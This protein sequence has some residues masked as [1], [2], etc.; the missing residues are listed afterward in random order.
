[1]VERRSQ[2]GLRVCTYKPCAE[3]TIRL[4][5]LTQGCL[6]PIA[7]PFFL[8]VVL[9]LSAGCGGVASKSQTV[10][11][12]PPAQDFSIT[13]S[14]TSLSLL[15]GGTSSPVNV[16]IAGQNGFTGTVQVSLSGLPSAVQSNPSSPF[17][18]AAGASTSVLFG[19]ASNAAAGNFTITAQGSSG[20]LSHSANLSLTVQT[21]V[22]SALPRTTYVRTGATAALDDPPSEPHHHHLVYHPSSKR[23]FIANRALNRVEVFS[24]TDQTRLA[25]I[26]VP[27][28]SSLD[29]SSDGATLWVGTVTQEIVAIDN[30]SLQVRT[31]YPIQPISPL[32]NSS[33]DRPEELIVLSSGNCLLRVRQSSGA[34][35]LLALWSPATNSLTNL[36]S[37]LPHGLAAMARTAD[38]TKVLVAA[39]DSTGVLTLLDSNGSILANPHTLGSGTIPLIA[40]NSDGSR[41]AAVLASGAS[42]QLFLLNGSLNPVGAPVS[43][44][45]RGVT[46]SRDG[47]FLYVSQ[48]GAPLAIAVFDGQNL[49][50]IGQVAD[51]SIEGVSS[52]IEDADETQ[53]LFGIANRGVSFVDAST[54]LPPIP[55]APA[56]AAAPV[57]Q[58]SE[59]PNVG[60]TSSSLAG[61]NFE[62]SVQLKF[63]THLATSVSVAGTTQMQA[64]S[65]PTVANGSVNLTAYFPS[66]WLALAPDAFSYGAQVLDL[67]PNAGA[68][69]GGE[70]IQIY[71]YGFGSDPSKINVTIGGVSGTVQKV[72]NV[73]ALASSL[74]LD[75][76]YPFSL[77]R[78]TLQT[79]AGTA[80]KA[81]LSLTAPAGSLSIPRAFQYLQSVQVNSKAALYKFLLYD[82][83]RQFVYMSATDHVD[84][85]D[86]HAGAFKPGGLP[87]ICFWSGQLLSGPCPNAGLRGMALTPD[88]S[89]LIVA[90]FGSQTIYL[91]NPDNPVTPTSPANASFVR[92]GG[93]AGFAASGPSRVAATSTKTVFVGL[94]GQGGTSAA[95]SSCLS[96]LDLTASPP[97]VQPAAE[98]EVTTVVGA[99]LVQATTAG[100]RVFLSFATAP[101]GPVGM[102][103]AASPKHFTTSATGETS[104]DL[105]AAADGT[106]FAT[107]AG[108]NAEIRG[109]DLTLQSSLAN[110]EL[111]RLPGRVSVPGITLHPT[112]SLVYQPFLTGP[113]PPE[114]PNPP[115]A[116][117]LR[118]GVDILDAH[119][120]RLRL[121]IFLPEP[122]AMRDTDVDGLHGGFLAIDENGQRI[123]ALTASG[124][125]IIQLASVPLGIGTL[126]PAAGPA[127]GGT[128]I[129]I[130]GSGFQSGTTVT[131]GGK[132]ASVT[133]KDINTLTVTAPALAAGSQQI[134]ITNPDGEISTLDAAFTAS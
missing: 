60:G 80:G 108:S 1:M 34:Q 17:G 25:Q 44:S 134:V 2:P 119:S 117:N 42:A 70:A 76:T 107:Y 20:S 38:H 18:I 118:G 112:G 87:L 93:V 110:P 39:S 92:V 125:T 120:G 66:G 21:S 72:E 55:V 9:S 57:A 56:F 35:G 68:P 102:W 26:D 12:P 31:R 51:A 71:G 49:Q 89:Q 97:T 61:Q 50:P 27:G 86:L 45:A 106:M 75:P 11:P 37:A 65:P 74:G 14:T 24:A 94:S 113:A 7:A 73:T 19:A 83:N 114:S 88:G 98:P 6:S 48:S 84:V 64:M 101:G 78:I 13:L 10:Q 53:L 99:P 115:P 8:A 15:Q 41:Y 67:L 62:S 95:C 63:G 130:R 127:A 128:V 116:P 82:Q 85:F 3:Q 90:D 131:I 91:L 111:E 22:V 40:A 123:F 4:N 100:D 129:T 47:K 133:F 77:E 103:D 46:F 33:F 124:L 54:P 121:R 28:A 96:Q 132:T 32:P 69:T 36:T 43:V 30:A 122:F 29:L 52:E 58:P 59:G 105:A 104:N 81:D 109:S 23:L 5:S 79:P 126:S 16:S